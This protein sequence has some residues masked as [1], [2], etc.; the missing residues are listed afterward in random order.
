VL[1]V[2][3]LLACGPGLSADAAKEAVQSAAV[4]ANPPGRTG[5]EL[6]GKSRWTQAPMFNREC[7]EQK[8]LAFA[9]TPA[10]RPASAGGIQRIS[11]TYKNQRYITSA[12]QDGWCVLIGED[13]QVSVGEPAIN[14]ESW[15][16]PVSYTM[17]SASPWFECL[18]S[19]WVGRTVQVSAN[20]AGEPV[21]DADLD[22]APGV[23][24]LPM[25]L[26]EERPAGQRPKK[27]PS[28]AP[29]KADVLKAAKAFD[30]ALWDHDLLG[31]LEHVSCYNLLEDQKYG[32]CTASE[33]IQVGPHPRGEQRM[34]DGV[35]W[36]ELVIRDLDDLGSIKK[37]AKI[38]TMFHVNV[39][40]KRTGR[41]RS[42]SVEWADGAWKLVGVLGRGSEDLASLRFMYDLHD[43]ERRD[44]FLRRLEGEAIDAKG[45]PLDPYASDDEEEEE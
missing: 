13:I 24:P 36:T 45:N 29:S 43:G 19:S 15:M 41:D 40:H 39:K 20:E 32:S 42:F 23:C 10:D 3:S 5:I 6:L 33:L 7:V 9:D 4:A 31:A 18:E 44:I 21:F 28:K 25:P 14:G 26:G 35:A 2:L 30:Q 16:V 1:I 17:R 38:P 37:D 12:T 27:A 8:D 11:P 34:E 22:L